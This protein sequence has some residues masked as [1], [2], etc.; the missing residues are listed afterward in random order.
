MI[1]YK[2]DPM[3]STEENNVGSFY[4]YSYNTDTATTTKNIIDKYELILTSLDGESRDQ[5]KTLVFDPK[6]IPNK[7]PKN[8]QRIPKGIPNTL[9]IWC[10]SSGNPWAKPSAFPK[11]HPTT[12]NF[13]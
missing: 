13:L 8:P 1:V 4:S 3:S 11:S 12:L 6:Q 7:S 9:S 5:T 10:E 2:I